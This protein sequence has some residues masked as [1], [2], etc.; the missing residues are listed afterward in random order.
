MQELVTEII[1]DIDYIE[2]KLKKQLKLLNEVKQE[3]KLAGS[4]EDLYKERL[5]YLYKQTMSTLQYIYNR[6]P[7]FAYYCKPDVKLLENPIIADEAKQ[8]VNIKVTADGIAIK[9]PMLPPKN[10]RPQYIFSNELRICLEE[11]FLA[12]NLP[13]YNKCII[14]FTQVYSSSY[15]SRHYVDNDNIDIKKTIDVI[16][17]YIT[18]SDN[19]LST[20]IFVQSVV[21]DDLDMGTYITVFDGEN[22]SNYDVF[23]RD[24]LYPKSQKNIWAQKK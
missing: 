20:K 10:K 13:S 6:I 9:I 4:E 8:L 1:D 11:L 21:D 15:S 7:N 18:G 14:V 16:T 23:L 2:A 24:F 5:E 3:V 17:D 22:S 19:A 12:G